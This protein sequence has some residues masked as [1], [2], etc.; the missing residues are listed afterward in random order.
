MKV[1]YHFATAQ[2]DC[3]MVTASALSPYFP[4]H[5]QQT[6]ASPFTCTPSAPCFVRRCLNVADTACLIF[7]TWRGA[8]V[9][10]MLSENAVF[11][12]VKQGRV[13]FVAC[14][15]QLAVRDD[16][17]E[18]GL[19]GA[20]VLLLTACSCKRRQVLERILKKAFS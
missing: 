7:A 13:P 10:K 11:L 1:C 6:S 15:V 18:F 5:S 8:E 4:K 2:K 19:H 12:N 14:H 17:Q 9:L 20:I 3:Q 16:P